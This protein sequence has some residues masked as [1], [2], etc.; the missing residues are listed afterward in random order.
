MLRAGGF[1]AYGVDIRWQGA[2][3]GDLEATELGRAGIL[4]YY[5]E[6][7]RLPFPDQRFE[8][9]V[10]DQVFEH[11]VELEPAIAEI[12]RVTRPGGVGYHHIPS[13][14][15]LREGHIGIPLAHRI[16]RGRLRLAYVTALRRLGAG[17]YPDARPPRVWR[18][19]TWTGSTVGRF[20][21]PRPSSTPP[22][23][24]VRG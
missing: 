18:R 14:A 6:G 12:E 11:V 16:P 8:L 10:S 4:R 5:Q 23:G 17:V 22:S 3:Y 19:R 2:D 1:D 21:V 13:R 20:T 15:V 7:G 24:P 9:A